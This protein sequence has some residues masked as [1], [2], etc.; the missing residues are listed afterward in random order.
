MFPLILIQ[1]ARGT[2]YTDSI[3]IRKDVDGS[4]DQVFKLGRN[5]SDAIV[6]AIEAGNIAA[7][8]TI[9]IGSA[10]LQYIYAPRVYKNL[11]G[12]PKTIVGNVSNTIGEYS[13]VRIDISRLRSF[14]VIGKRSDFHADHV[15]GEDI[16]SDPY[17]VGTQWVNVEEPIAATLLPNF[18][19][20]YFGHT[21]IHGDIRSVEVQDQFQVR[22]RGYELW[23]SCAMAAFT[24]LPDINTFLDSIDP[25][26]AEG[27][28]PMDRTVLDG[29]I[30]RFLDPSWTYPTSVPLSLTNGP[31]STFDTM[32]PGDYPQEAQELAEIFNPLPDAPTPTAV[33]AGAAG[34]NPTFKIS[35]ETE[36]NKERDSKKGIV[37]LMLFLIAAD[38]DFQSGNVTNFTQA[39]PTKGM[40]CVME[41]SG[42]AR[43]QSYADLLTEACSV[44][45][46]ADPLSI[47]SIHM[48]MKVISK[49]LA[50]NLIAGNFAIT[51][52]K[53]LLHDANSIDPSVFMPQR[54]PA[55]VASVKQDELLLMNEITMG[56]PTAQRDYRPKT[57]IARI[58]TNRSVDD[59]TSLCVNID[60][61]ITATAVV[62][63]E[64]PA[65]ILHQLMMDFIKTVNSPQWNRW[66]ESA[67][68][69]MP[70]V[71]LALYGY[72]ERIWNLFGEFAV[73]FTNGNLVTAGG[74]L[75][76]LNTAPI[77]EAVMG[78]TT[79]K[80]HLAQSQA[81][82]MP[83]AY[84]PSNIDALMM[85]ATP[86]TS[87]GGSTSSSRE[88]GA[89]NRANNSTGTASRARDTVGAA[90]DRNA[91]SST[92]RGG[93]ANSGQSR[94]AMSSTNK[95]L[96]RN[97]QGSG[98]DASSQPRQPMTNASRGMFYLHHTAICNLSIF[99][100]GLPVKIC[101]LVTCKG[102]E[103]SEGMAEECPLG[104]HYKLATDIHPEAIKMIGKHF[105]E[106]NVGW[107]NE[108]HFKEVRSLSNELKALCGNARGPRA[109]SAAA[110]GTSS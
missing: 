43:P 55:K 23:A 19:P 45:A 47:R 65:P 95:R 78:Y 85:V 67:G 58:G 90:A 98:N 107:F 14:A 30:R 34:E 91:S 57:A 36:E 64:G 94:G 3:P 46:T 49:T 48:T 97:E 73:K 20:L 102:K 71:H 75:D 10:Y 74:L 87:S 68:S 60:T 110:Q 42:A 52:V 5:S 61:F 109:A 17:L 28:D 6:E 84:V 27:V 70:Y 2:S 100:H 96:R 93:G 99:P 12:R 53:D 25:P 69:R 76:G 86:S 11:R 13:V 29:N 79:F 50:S 77:I 51:E 59:F 106:K 39:T 31:C 101:P 92:N 8:G 15:L 56:V 4:S 38:V 63:G 88:T 1:L 62:D 66:H 108:Y 82:G 72:L 80:T 104:K 103:C 26:A 16:P 81:L 105:K 83:L 54:C 32:Q 41:M 24:N 89:S 37:K 33:L 40:E 35:V 44:A 22:G 18:F 21:P 9:N 7:I